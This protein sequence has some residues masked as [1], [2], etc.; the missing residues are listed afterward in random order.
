MVTSFAQMK[1]AGVKVTRQ[2]TQ[3]ELIDQTKINEF[4]RANMAYHDLKDEIKKL[5]KDLENL[6][7]ASMQVDEAM[8]E[9]GAL[10]LF[11]GEAFIAVDDDQA[12]KYV[13]KL[14]EEKQ[15]EVEAK[16]D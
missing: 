10:K 11:L 7:D 15:E 16:E 8:G 14:Q 3:I 13:E 2:D 1:P 12:A 4:S 6:D 9:E 5:K